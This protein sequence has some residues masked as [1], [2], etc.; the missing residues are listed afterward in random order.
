[1]KGFSVCLRSE[2]GDWIFKGLKIWGTFILVLEVLTHVH[3]F[4]ILLILV[5]FANLVL[6]DYLIDLDELRCSV[7]Q[8]YVIA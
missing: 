7:N 6:F 4:V 3:Q 5:N 2:A 1:M 8:L